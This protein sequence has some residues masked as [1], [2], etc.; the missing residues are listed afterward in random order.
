MVSEPGAE[1]VIAG[2][3][4]LSLILIGDTYEDLQV[5]DA[6]KAVAYRCWSEFLVQ[7]Q[8][9]PKAVDLFAVSIPSGI[10]GHRKDDHDDYR[11]TIYLSAG[12]IRRRPDR[13]GGLSW[14][15]FSIFPGIPAAG[16]CGPCLQ[17]R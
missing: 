4:E 16:R 6:M 11:S 2:C 5:V 8:R 17:P 10:M 9:W 15:G 3:T 1:A 14:T 13:P 7:I 12:V